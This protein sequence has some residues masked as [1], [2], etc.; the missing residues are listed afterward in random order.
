MAART[1]TLLLAVA[2]LLGAGWWFTAGSAPDDAAPPDQAAASNATA[3]ASPGQSEPASN[4]HGEDP[5]YAVVLMYHRFGE[6][7][8]PATSIRVE[9]FE[10]H[11]EYLQEHDFN[12]VPLGEIIDHFERDEPLPPRTLAITVDDA[13]RS[14][15]DVARPMLAAADMPW[16]LFVTTDQP[17]RQLGDFMSWDDLRELHEDPMVTIGHH[18]GAH[19]HMPDHDAATNRHDT[20]R[21]NQRF[22]E[23][24]GD[25]PDLYAYPFGEYDDAVLAVMD[26]FEFRAAFGQHSGVAHAAEARME[27]PRFAMN[28]NW[29]TMERF[30]ERVHTKPLPV[31][32]ISPGDALVVQDN[33]PAFSFTL[34]HDGVNAAQVGCFPSGGL[35]AEVER[36]GNRLTVTP[37][38]AFSPGRARIN[39]T[40]PYGDGTHRWFGRQFVV[41]EPDGDSHVPRSDPGAGEPEAP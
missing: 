4:S 39:C 23:E 36:D 37:S 31:T 9:Q 11:I 1:L 5:P 25:V 41:R 20:R 19:H 35:Q 12:V 29:G 15:L 6:D 27:L 24:L 30:T 3:N 40:A 22:R 7:R 13:Y 17:D 16:T 2:L 33:P 38:G 21:A 8:Y 18:S 32:D 14:A 26:E 34:A 10:A 28:E